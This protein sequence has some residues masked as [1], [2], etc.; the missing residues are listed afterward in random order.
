MP[1]LKKVVLAMGDRLIYRDTFEEAGADLAGSPV[2]TA[3]TT[4][5]VKSGLAA[6]P[7]A[8]GKDLP[9]LAERLSRLREQAEELARELREL[10]SLEKQTRKQ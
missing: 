2:L 6:A 8:T 1:Q 4:G 9:A 5:A 3:P 7:A 10:E